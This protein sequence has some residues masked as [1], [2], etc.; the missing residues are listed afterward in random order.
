MGEAFYRAI[1]EFRRKYVT[2]EEQEKALREMS[3]DQIMQLSRS[4]KSFQEACY[5]ARL[6]QEAAIR[7]RGMCA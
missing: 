2:R 5:Y 1:T 7:E 4:C 3:A 6:A